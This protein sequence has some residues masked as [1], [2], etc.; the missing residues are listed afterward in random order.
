MLENQIGERGG[1]TGFQWKFER[2]GR[3][4]DKNL[5]TSDPSDTRGTARPDPC[6]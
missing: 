4:L 5:I 1:F 2:Y 3:H 6:A